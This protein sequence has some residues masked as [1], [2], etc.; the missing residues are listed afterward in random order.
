M[1]IKKVM[2][3]LAAVALAGCVSFELAPLADHLV[4]AKSKGKELPLLSKQYPQMS[5]T[6]AYDIQGG[7][8]RRTIGFL[9]RTVGGYKGGLTSESSW[10]KFAVESPV[11]GVLPAQGQ[12]GNGAKISLDS[13]INPM[14]EVELAFVFS[15][16]INSEITSVEQLKDK[17]AF[18]APAL[19]LPDLAFSDLDNLTGKDLIA[20]NVAASRYMVG[21]KVDNWQKVNLD[22]LNVTLTHQGQVVSRGEGSDA[23]GSQWQAALWLVNELVRQHKVIRPGDVLLTGSLGTMVQAEAGDYQAD[24]GELGTLRVTFK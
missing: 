5:L 9:P 14:I 7:F 1:K 19:E 12:L 21:T 22:G 17:V 23:M 4:V 3:G 15:K 11:T 16:R 6:Q 24:F 2:M 13:F 8:V 18:V 20:A 10:R